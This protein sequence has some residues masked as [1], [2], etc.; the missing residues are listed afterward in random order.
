MAAFAYADGN[1]LTAEQLNASFSGTAVPVAT[2]AA[3]G[4]DDTTQLTNAFAY[5][6]ASPGNSISF[7]PGKTYTISALITITGA[8]NFQIFGNGATI[9]GGSTYAPVAGN[10][11]ILFYG[12]NAN[13][14]VFDLHLNGN[15]TARNPTAEVDAHNWEVQGTTS[16]TSSFIRFWGCRS[17]NSICDNWCIDAAGTA[18]SVLA[19]LPT[20]IQLINCYGTQAYRNSI[21]VVNS[22]RFRVYGGQFTYSN[23]T[24]PMAGIDVEANNA[25][26]VNGD[27]GNVD[28][29]LYNMECFGNS[30]YDFSFTVNSTVRAFNIM[31][32]GGT[33]GAVIVGNANYVEI[34]GITLDS[35]TNTVQSGVIAVNNTAGEIHIDDVR[36]TNITT[37]NNNLPLIS[38]NGG[39]TGPVTLGVVRATSCNAPLLGTGYVGLIV[40][41]LNANGANQGQM[42]VVNGAKTTIKRLVGVNV[43]GALYCNAPDCELDDVTL[44]NPTGTNTQLVWF[45][46]GSTNPILR[47]MRV[48]QDTAI[49][50]G[51]IAAYFYSAPLFVGDVIGRCGGATDYTASPS[52]LITFAGGVSGSE[53]GLISPSPL[54][55]AG[56][57]TPG[58]IGNG[59]V[60]QSTGHTLTGAALGDQVIATYSQTLSGVTLTGYVSAANTVAA[61]FANNTGS[62]VTPAAGTL[63]LRLVKAR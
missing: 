9:Q 29:R 24:L 45:D 17:I 60:Y 2:F 56:S 43:T 61:T 38:V 11:L 36:A 7:A 46:N 10:G 62:T 18:I 3:G 41:E 25:A 44:I 15:R 1:V 47:G 16:G 57:V 28:C 39:V 33:S 21:S 49:P 14:D 48:H 50:T 30:G 5:L 31:G 59:A 63:T 19:D 27:L 51:Q 40:D 26:G 23:G 42:V 52:S 13:G 54:V 12:A 37:G 55:F 20:D 32:H 22:N 34:N 6:Q 8:S 58:A 53:I 35:Y 4:S